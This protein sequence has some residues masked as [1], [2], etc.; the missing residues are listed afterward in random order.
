MTAVVARRAI[1]DHR[2]SIIAYCVGT[3]SIMAMMA[4]VYPSIRGNNLYDELVKQYPKEILSLL[5]AGSGADFSGG[6]GFLGVEIMGF[7]APLLFLIQS[8]GFGAGAMT[9]EEER[10]ELDLV[11]S[12]PVTRAHVLVEKLGALVV[13]VFALT[14]AFTASTIVFGAIGDMGLVTANVVA[15][16]VDLF[17]LAVLL[18]VISLAIGAATGSRGAALGGAGGLAVATYLVSGLS[19]IASWLKPLRPL[20]PFYQTVAQE[21]LVNGFSP[22]RTLAVLGATVVVAVVGAVCFQ[23]RDIRT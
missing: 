20:S 8:V 17:V 3:I 13:G 2:R 9:G 15:G 18:G 12:A 6:A 19:E 14:V 22:W 1:A 5:G 11:L 4:A 7:M 21:P 16:G 10:G 23:R